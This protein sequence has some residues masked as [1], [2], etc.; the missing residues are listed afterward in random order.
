VQ[1][2][3]YGVSVLRKERGLQ[4][5]GTAPGSNLIKAFIHV[6]GRAVAKGPAQASHQERLRISVAEYI[7]S[8]SSEVV[9]IVGTPKS[10]F[11]DP[12]FEGVEPL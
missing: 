7:P 5:Q 8:N 2:Q 6:R 1:P 10:R 4:L 9:R 3:P 12:S 11:A